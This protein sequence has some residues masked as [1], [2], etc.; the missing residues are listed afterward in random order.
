LVEN[1]PIRNVLATVTG[2]LVAGIT[3]HIFE[4]LIGH[5]V[6]PLPGDY[7]PTIEWLSANMSRISIGSKAFVVIGHFL[8]PICGMAVA[9][10]I[11]KTSMIPAYIVGSIMLI[12][13]A[14]FIIKLPKE[15]WFT[16]TKRTLVYYGRYCIYYC[17][18]LLW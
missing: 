8:G 11:S 16:I 6:F 9:G 14:F 13:T 18:F 10:M 4:A 2:I 3:V 1:K 7:Q 15:L 12:A 17:R 5:N